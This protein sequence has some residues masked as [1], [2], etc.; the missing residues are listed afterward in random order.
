VTS[1]LNSN[2]AADMGSAPP[3]GG[4]YEVRRTDQ[5]WSSPG[6]S[7]TPQNLVGAFATQTFLLPRVSRNL[8]YFIRP[9]AADGRTSRHS[10]VVAVHYPLV[11]AAPAALNI[12]FGE[13]EQQ[14][15]VIRCAVAVAESGIADVD[16]VELRD[17]DDATV[18]ARWS[19]AQLEFGEGAYRARL[20]LDNSTALARSKTLHAYTQN[21]LG[22]YSAPR[23]ATASVPVPDK[24][25]LAVGHS[26]GQILEVLLDATPGAIA[27]TQV[28]VIEPAGTFDAPAQDVRLP[29]Q[30][31]KFSFVATR[32]GSWRF[33]A[34]RRDALGWSPWSTEPQGQLP[35]Q[36]LVFVVQFF[37]APEL[38]PSIGAAI[39]T[40]N[41]LPNSDFFHGGIA[42]QEDI[43]APRYF[44]LVNASSGGTELA[45][46]GATNEVEWKSG[47]SFGS[48]NPGFRSL[49]T[50]LG[51]LFN[52]GE[53]LTLSAALR[54]SG[55]LAFPH[56]VR[57]ALRSAAN[58]SYDRTAD[59]PAGTIA[60][61]YQWYSVTLTLAAAE[62]VPADLSIE[63]TVVAAA[64]QSLASSLFCDKVILNRGHRPAAFSLAPWDV[65][66]LSWNAAAG[67][68][69]LPASAVAPVARNSD[70]GGAGLLLGTGT[71]DLDPDF[72]SRYFRQVA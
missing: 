20:A 36:D 8:A 44:A 23:T 48:A 55:A 42:G 28:Q 58:P 49:L 70:P 38:D 27:E 41:L 56:A 66:A 71:E 14:K 40:Q 25:V 5:G 52:P 21:T 33:R 43:Y 11:P 53:A 51:R 9:V 2:F 64:G 30:P 15:P 37:Q 22:E 29:G 7:G 12:A 19:F 13:D 1:V 54:H 6:A 50:N 24:P 18:L 57:F 31:E 39:N 67:A 69:D 3:A 65:L 34:R 4:R 16:Q 47:V 32:S 59:V 17:T 45:Y 62:A 68:Y 63:V 35:G 72:A 61:V 46:S 10:S 26:V 60:S